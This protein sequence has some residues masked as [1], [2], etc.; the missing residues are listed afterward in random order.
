VLTDAGCAVLDEL[1]ALP[2]R[3]GEVTQHM[4]DADRAASIQ[5]T[6][7]FTTAH[8]ALTDAARR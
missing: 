8:L 3:G 4:S 2:I 7:A 5:D 6:Q 1:T